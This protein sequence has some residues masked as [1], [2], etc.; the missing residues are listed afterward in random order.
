MIWL[1]GFA[2]ALCLIGG[3]VAV[4]AAG[5]ASGSARNAAAAERGAIAARVD[6]EISSRVART[7]TGVDFSFDRTHAAEVDVSERIRQ[8]LMTAGAT[9]QRINARAAGFRRAR[10][11]DVFVKPTP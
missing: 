8:D 2:G 7:V 11:V 1:Y 6:A 10:H 9:A 3:L 5:R 4:S